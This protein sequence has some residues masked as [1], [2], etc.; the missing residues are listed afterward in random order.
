MQTFGQVVLE[1]LAFGL[2]S[3]PTFM[4]ALRDV[5]LKLLHL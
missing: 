5:E 1:A 2:V 3:W 4:L